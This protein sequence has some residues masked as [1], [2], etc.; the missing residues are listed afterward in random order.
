MYGCTVLRKVRMPAG[1]TSYP[2]ERIEI[3]FE[4][5]PEGYDMPYVEP[6]PEYMALFHE[7]DSLE[8]LILPNTL[9]TVGAGTFHEP[10]RDIWYAGTQEEWAQVT[11]GQPNLLPNVHFGYD[12]G[13]ALSGDI[14][15][16]NAFSVTDAVY[17]QRY[18]LGEFSLNEAAFRNADL[19]GDGEVDVFDLSLLKQSLLS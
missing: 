7:C 18:L 6:E 15:L 10:L 9:Q 5:P 16:D 12:E 3:C 1:I 17:L 14:T 8:T 13:S 2:S 19:N 11:I 4:A